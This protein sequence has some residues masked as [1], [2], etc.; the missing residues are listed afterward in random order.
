VATAAEVA[1]RVASHLGGDLGSRLSPA[2]GEWHADLTWMAG[3]VPASQF[4]LAI[5]PDGSVRWGSG[6]LVLPGEPAEP[7]PLIGVLEAL[8]RLNAPPR[9]GFGSCASCS[10]FTV[11]D[12]ALGYTYVDGRFEPSYWF[13]TTDYDVRQIPAT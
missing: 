4:M 6:Q 3:D 12:V 9:T 2:L 1:Q 5:R 10:P 13:T 8:H 7:V 11:T